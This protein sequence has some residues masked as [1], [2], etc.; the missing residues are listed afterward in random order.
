MVGA[1]YQRVKISCGLVKLRHADANGEA[2]GLLPKYDGLFGHG[3]PES[4]RFITSFR[5]IRV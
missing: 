2:D 5:G 4:F 1:V 3:F